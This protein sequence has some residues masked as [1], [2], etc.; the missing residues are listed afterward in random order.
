M[1]D[2]FI[3]HFDDSI[4]WGVIAQG[5]FA[6][7]LLSIQRS[8]QVANRFL[9]LLLLSFSLWLCD[10]FFRVST[11][12]TQDPDFDFYRFFILSVLDL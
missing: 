5:F 9:A 6:S 1:N 4:A 2:Q 3:L 8:N 12:Y 11:I 10:T 7:L